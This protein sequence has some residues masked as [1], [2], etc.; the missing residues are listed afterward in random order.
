GHIVGQLAAPQGI[1]E[2]VKVGLV[3]HQT[4]WMLDILSDP[5]TTG[6]CIVTTGEEM[7]VA[8]AIDLAGRI[9]RDTTVELA[10]V[11][12]NRV[13][14]E[15]FGRGEQVVFD[16]LGSRRA[17]AALSAGTGQDAASITAVLEAA[18]LASTIRRTG[19]GHLEELRAGIDASVPLMYLPYLFGRAHGLR[20][21]RQVASALS[22]ELGF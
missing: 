1:N 14:P 6:V 22:D 21:V 9:K 3:R 2:L 12:A 10:C 11:I 16:A 4:D 15:L 5:A 8:E 19:A 17:K 20:A 13:L 7:P 18:K